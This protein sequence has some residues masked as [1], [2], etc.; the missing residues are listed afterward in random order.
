MDENTNITGTDHEEVAGLKEKAE[1]KLS[2]L[3]A[4]AGEWAEKAEDK[5][6]DLKEKAEEKFEEFK[7][8]AEDVV[9]DL[10]EKATNLWEKVKDQFDGDEE[11][12]K[13]EPA[14]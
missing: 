12:P 11:P 8:K 6:E 4:T 14:K 3:K 13:Q 5:L 10:K 1:D 7:E 2:E 9:D